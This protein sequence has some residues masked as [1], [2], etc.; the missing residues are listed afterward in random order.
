[1][2]STYWTSNVLMMLA[3]AEPLL[4]SQLT[5]CRVVPRAINYRV[6]I[7]NHPSSQGHGK[8]QDAPGA[9]NVLEASLMINVS[10]P[11]NLKNSDLDKTQLQAQNVIKYIHFISGMRGMNSSYRM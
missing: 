1:M 4:K 6:L 3:H 8:Y 11:L 2:L 9:T 5:R 10:E 7:N